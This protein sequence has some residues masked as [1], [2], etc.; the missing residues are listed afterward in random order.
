MT[1]IPDITLYQKRL[2]ILQ[3]TAQ[4]I[5]KDFE[6][7]GI[8]ITFSGRQETAYLELY[9]Q[10]EPEIARLLQQNKI[11]QLLYR[12]DISELQINKAIR[13]STSKTLPSA[14]TDLVIKRELQ[15]VVIR[16]SYKI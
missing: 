7:V 15:K 3:Q 9:Q 13:N 4:Q 5:I 6:L 2:D 14:I 12:I 11:N 16:N 10:I 8:E 1:G